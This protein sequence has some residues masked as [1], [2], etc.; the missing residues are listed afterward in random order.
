VS[1]LEVALRVVWSG[2]HARG[3]TLDDV[4]A[5]MSAAPAALAGLEGAKGAIAAGRDADLVAFAPD[6]IAEV[7]PAALHHRHPV[8]PYAGLA[9]RGAVRRVWLRGTQLVES[10]MAGAGGGRL[11]TPERKGTT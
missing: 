10:D 11:L 4:A 1:S 5:W 6:E 9:L 2:A 3:H 7:D 8:T